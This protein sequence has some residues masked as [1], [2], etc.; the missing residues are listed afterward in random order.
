M[1]HHLGRSRSK[2]IFHLAT[3]W[4]LGCR[5]L[6]RSATAAAWNH[7][8]SEDIFRC[9]LWGETRRQHSDHPATNVLLRRC[10]ARRSAARNWIRRYRRPESPGTRTAT[11]RTRFF[12]LREKSTA[13]P[14][15]LSLL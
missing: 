7:L 4:G 11:I 2:S 8:A 9:V 6:A 14:S 3:N 15:T 10:R 13:A 1:A 12:S 5:L